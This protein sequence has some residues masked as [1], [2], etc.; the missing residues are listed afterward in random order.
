M[1]LFKEHLRHAVKIEKVSDTIGD[2]K[3]GE[4]YAL[5]CVDCDERIIDDEV[6][7]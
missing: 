3:V 4:C 6:F 2:E 5:V 7:K 1:N